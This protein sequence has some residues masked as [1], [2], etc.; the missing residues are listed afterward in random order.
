MFNFEIFRLYHLVI[1]FILSIE[2]NNKLLVE[3]LKEFLS[4]E[5]THQLCLF[6]LFFVKR[7]GLSLSIGH[8]NIG[9]WLCVSA[10]Q[11]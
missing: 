5:L 10:R 4:F 9:S 7:E 1:T 11:L 3:F 8:G 2:G 6:N